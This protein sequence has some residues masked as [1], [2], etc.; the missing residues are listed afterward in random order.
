MT[1]P[2]EAGRLIL[3][4]FGTKLVECHCECDGFYT[5]DDHLIID[6]L[7]DPAVPDSWLPIL[8]TPR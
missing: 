3:A 1:E 2:P 8:Q 6:E 4:R 5:R 7:G